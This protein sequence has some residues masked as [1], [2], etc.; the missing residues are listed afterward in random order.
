MDPSE[1]HK[2]TMYKMVGNEN[3]L[4][5][6]IKKEIHAFQWE[7]IW[8]KFLEVEC[9]SRIGKDFSFWTL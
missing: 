3:Y 5:A 9:F 4:N 6:R 7:M 8:I 2:K 1:R